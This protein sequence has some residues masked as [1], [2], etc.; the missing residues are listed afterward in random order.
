MAGWAAA[1]GAEPLT[2]PHR[3]P[4]ATPRT[5]SRRRVAGGVLWIGA[6]AALLAGIVAMNV[7]V[8]RLNIQ[9]DRLGHTRDTLRA[10]NASLLSQLS[11][12]GATGRIQTLAMNRLGFVQAGPDQ[13]TFV[14][15][16]R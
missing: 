9:L 5:R 8:L 14:R 2:A 3:R 12:A 13:T 10:E 4:R 16:A 15:L 6:V 7:A 11:S 1:A